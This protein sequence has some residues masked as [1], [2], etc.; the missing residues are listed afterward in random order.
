VKAL[1]FDMFGTVLDWRTSVARETEALLRPRGYHL[2]WLAFADAWRN[3]YDPSMAPIREGKRPFVILDVLHRENLERVL[4]KFGVANLPDAITHDLTLAWHRLDGWP[5][6][7]PGMAALGRHFLLAPCS[8]GNIAMMEDVAKRNDIR[9]DAILGAEP[10]RDYKTKPRVYLHAAEALDLAPQELMM[11][12][13]ASHGADLA[14][15]AAQGLRTAAIARPHESGPGK[16]AS[17]PSVPVD[18]IA[19]DLIDLAAKL[20]G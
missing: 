17:V 12:C 5:D 11:V 10:A 13:A 2:N 19:A 7:T 6:A 14:A 18:I 9:F 3:E 1:V 16:G 20:S 4:P 15:A 8:N